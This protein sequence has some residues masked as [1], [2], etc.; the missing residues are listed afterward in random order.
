MIDEGE[1]A[2]TAALRELKEETGYIATLLKNSKAG[3]EFIMHNDPGF[4]N[5]NTKMIFVEVDMTDPRNQ[6]PE[7]D[8]E[9]NEYIEC[10]TV[11]LSDLWNQ[12][13]SLDK[14]GFA[15]DAR[16]GTLAQGWQ[17]ARRWKEV[18][19]SSSS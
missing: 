10:F 3:D 11:P 16:V 15:I 5:T 8:L 2:A 1:D 6:N 18:L 4:C 12:L 19:D 9:E 7:P 13:V 14:E 17:M